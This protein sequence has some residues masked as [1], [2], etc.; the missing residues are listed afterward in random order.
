MLTVILQK[1][2]GDVMNYCYNE[3]Q[4]CLMNRF[5]QLWVQ[6]VYWTRF[7]IISTV[8]GLEDLD[9]VTARL[10]QN[11]RDFADV[12][13]SFYGKKTAERFQELF[14]EHLLIA[15]DL[16]NAA[17]NKDTA[18]VD[19]TRKKWYENADEI[20]CFLSKINPYWDILRW[21]NMLYSHLE[22]TEKEATLR[23]QGNYS[24][25]IKN[26][27]RI[28]KEALNMA[29]YMFCGIINQCFR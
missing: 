25:D 5:R 29:D 21:R 6:H 19:E 16:V 15:G 14:T 9:V 10:L 12:L 8:S 26:F 13:A 3:K 20:A 24:E 11:P 28:E 17:K 27:E 4:I 7:F 18:K 23:L 22:M 1:M 2:K